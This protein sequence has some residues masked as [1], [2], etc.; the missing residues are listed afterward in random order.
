MTSGSLR[1]KKKSRIWLKQNLLLPLFIEFIR[2]FAVISRGILIKRTKSLLE[3]SVSS[4]SKAQ[5]NGQHKT[6]TNPR[7]IHPSISWLLIQANCWSLAQISWA[8]SRSRRK[9]RRLVFFSRWKS[10]EWTTLI[11]WWIFKDPMKL[12]PSFRRQHQT[13]IVLLS[14]EIV[15]RMRWLTRWPFVLGFRSGNMN[16]TTNKETYKSDFAWKGKISPKSSKIIG[17]K[18]QRKKC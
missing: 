18:M 12:W 15:S 16:T 3:E 10:Q 2:L 14:K 5:R 1:Q 7:E 8:R 11:T 6:I 13:E 9:C 4:L 17:I